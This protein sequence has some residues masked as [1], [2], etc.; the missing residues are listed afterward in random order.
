[1]RTLDCWESRVWEATISDHG[2]WIWR[3]TLWIVG[4]PH[5]GTLQ[6][7]D[8]D[9]GYGDTHASTEAFNVNVVYKIVAY[10]P[11]VRINTRIVVVVTK[12]DAKKYCDAPSL[13]CALST[14][15][16]RESLARHHCSVVGN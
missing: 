10:S 3:R 8:T 7:R 11:R 14:I 5:S 1:M 6:S 4:D 12:T 15:A 2:F 16:K 13:A 9:F